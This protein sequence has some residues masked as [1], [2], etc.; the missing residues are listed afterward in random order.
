MLGGGA[1][2]SVRRTTIEIFLCVSMLLGLVA[3]RHSVVSVSGFLLVG[4]IG[5]V[6]VLLFRPTPFTLMVIV[7]IGFVIGLARASLF[8]S[9]ANAY[10]KLHGHTVSITVQALDDSLYDEHGLLTFDA[11][12]VV[13]KGGQSIKGRVRVSGR[14]VYMVYAGDTVRV[15]GRLYVTRGSRQARISFAQLSVISRSD[16]VVYRVRRRFVSSLQSLLPE[17]HASLGLGLLVGQRDT[18]PKETSEQM[19]AI[20]LTHIVAVSGYNLTIIL[21]LSRRIFE[22][23]SKYQTMLGAIV[24]LVFF[25]LITGFSASIVRAAVVA[26]FGIWAW[27]YGRK[28]RPILLIAVAATLTA[29]WNPFYLWADV[30]WYL[31]FL[32]FFGVLIVAPIVQRRLFPKRKELPLLALVAIESFAAQAMV[33]P[34]IMYLFGTFSPVSLIANVLVVPLIP[35]AM[36]ATFVPGVLGLLTPTAAVLFVWP[37]RLLLSYMLDVIHAL[38]T[39]PFASLQISM[40]VT[41]MVVWYIGIL[42]ALFFAARK[43][44]NVV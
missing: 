33:M 11:S 34:F 36:L 43:I 8:A 2:R 16:S 30:G 4:M 10:Q 42:L 25:M 6:V 18:L 14:G 26:G 39:L 44:R 13:L 37:A 35:I 19:S 22:K 23:R 40:T 38:S 28:I 15:V 5:L 3:G 41:H 1:V 21:L 29:M 24:L 20:G 9:N 32:A 31:S 7:I 12:N 17:P 27:F